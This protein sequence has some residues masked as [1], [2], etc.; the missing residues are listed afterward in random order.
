MKKFV[1]PHKKLA[2]KFINDVGLPKVTYDKSRK[3]W[4]A[5]CKNPF[6]GYP[7]F[8][9]LFR[10]E[11]KAHQAWLRQKRTYMLMIYQLQND[12]TIKEALLNLDFGKPE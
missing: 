8:I 12:E 3:H 7:V 1:D 2:E 11:E 6:G 5:R 10:T 9:G 4:K